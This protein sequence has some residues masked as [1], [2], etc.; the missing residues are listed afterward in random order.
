MQL[1]FG[2]G[3]FRG[4]RSFHRWPHSNTVSKDEE[5][6][7]AWQ[8]SLLDDPYSHMTLPVQIANTTSVRRVNGSSGT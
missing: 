6:V 2:T 3:H 7:A 5:A 8:R 1:Q 4:S